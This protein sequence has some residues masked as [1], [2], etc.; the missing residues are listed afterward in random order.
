MPGG[1][2][3]VVMN[4][5]LT[6]AV[7]HNYANSGNFARVWRHAKHVRT[8][9]A[10]AYEWLRVFLSCP[11]LQLTTQGRRKMSAK[12]L[13]AL[14]TARPDLAATAS[15]LAQRGEDDSATSSS[16]GSSS[17]SSNSSDGSSDDDEKKGDG[18]AHGQH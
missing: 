3:H 12:W 17:S 6:I 8:R 9:C 15:K 1:W 5:D 2:W 7:T 4:L 14:E 11:S 16:S 13:A 18:D 10:P